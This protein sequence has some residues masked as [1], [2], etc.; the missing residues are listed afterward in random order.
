MSHKLSKITISIALIAVFGLFN[1]GVPIVKYLCP[2][3]SMENPTCDLSTSTSDA[4]LAF[5]AQ[6]PSCCAKYIVAERNTT[7][8]LS[9]EKYS[10]PQ[11]EVLMPATVASISTIEFQSSLIFTTDFSPPLSHSGEPLFLLNSSFLI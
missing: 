6:T 7:P 11:L 9:I 8:F 3:M 5:S 10:V 4:A 2:M 1:V